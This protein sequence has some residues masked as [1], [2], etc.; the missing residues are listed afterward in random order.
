[1]E[2]SK[3]ATSV[4]FSPDGKLL[5]V[6]VHN[7][8]QLYDW[9]RG[10][11]VGS[12]FSHQSEEVLD[13]HFLANSAWVVTFSGDGLVQVWDRRDGRPVF[14][15]PPS[16]R[17]QG[18]VLARN[19]RTLIAGGSD[20]RARLYDLDDLL[21]PTDIATSPDPE[22]DQLCRLA[23]FLSGFKLGD[24]M[25]PVRLAAAERQ[26]LAKRCKEEG[27]WRE[28][29]MGES[30]THVPATADAPRPNN[31]VMPGRARTAPR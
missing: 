6:A 18:P 19:G 24:D 30:F 29:E 12:Y 25:L 7:A 8:A 17:S 23:K 9:R 26:A 13:A 4:G 10:R 16:L 1:L 5:I 3:G 21:I 31:N 27:I 28:A 22:A 2:Q 20:G 15:G 14:I 11:L